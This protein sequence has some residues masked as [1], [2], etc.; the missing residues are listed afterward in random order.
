MEAGS[1]AAHWLDPELIVGEAEDI[2]KDHA[3]PVEAFEWYPVGREVGN[4]RN[5][6]R[7]LIRPLQ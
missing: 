7:Q 5:E 3:E 6:G 1:C 4:V 2:V